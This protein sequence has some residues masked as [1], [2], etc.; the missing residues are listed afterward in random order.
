M[1]PV[2]IQLSAFILLVLGSALVEYSAAAP[3]APSDAKSGLQAPAGHHERESQRVRARSFDPDLLTGDS[4]PA[5]FPS[6]ANTPSSSGLLTNTP[7][8]SGVINGDARKLLSYQAAPK[9][10]FQPRR[11]QDSSTAEDANQFLV[12][13]SSDPPTLHRRHL[14]TAAPTTSDEASDQQLPNRSRIH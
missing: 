11:F 2:K 4:T 3:T 8:G 5:T 10:S 12:S 7:P 1:Y 6:Q 9:T 14:L 13:P